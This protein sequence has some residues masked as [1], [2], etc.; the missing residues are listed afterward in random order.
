MYIDNSGEVVDECAVLTYL[1]DL[2][3]TSNVNMFGSIPYVVRVFG[4]TK[5]E[6]TQMVLTWMKQFDEINS[7]GT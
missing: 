5:S 6:A 2:R 3:A 4:V 1:D 7:I